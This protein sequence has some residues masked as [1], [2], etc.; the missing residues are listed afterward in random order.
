MTPGILEWVASVAPLVNARGDIIELGAYDVNG[1]PRHLFPEAKSY[2][3]VD[4]A[5]GRNVVLVT[6]VRDVLSVVA[7][8]SADLVICCEMLEH[9]PTPFKTM[10]IVKQLLRQ[11]TRSALCGA[12]TDNTSR[13][14]VTRTTFRPA[15]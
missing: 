14:G 3:G 6:P 5:A 8:Q 15:A 9:D 11:I 1:N 7:P 10:E 2:L 4:Q 13:T 12:T